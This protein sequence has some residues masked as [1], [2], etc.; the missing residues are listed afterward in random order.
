MAEIGAVYDAT[1]SPR[2]PADIM[3]RS[4]GEQREPTPGPVATN[5]W[6]CASIVKDAAVVIEQVLEE[7]QRRDPEH[8]RRW[9]ALVDGNNHQ[10]QRIKAGAK[11]RKVKVTIVVDFIHVLD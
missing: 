11:A 10:I 9:V 8:H 1:P 6:L 5:K 3:S 4:Q 2:T 7:A